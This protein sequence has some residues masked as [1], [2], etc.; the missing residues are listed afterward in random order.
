M[1]S[2][3]YRIRTFPL[4]SINNYYL[5]KQEACHTGTEKGG[6]EEEVEV[7]L[8]LAE[9]R[10]RLAPTDQPRFICLISESEKPFQTLYRQFFTF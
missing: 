10:K 1:E 8:V 6:R 4:G 7:V 2:K 5:Q 3:R 9:I